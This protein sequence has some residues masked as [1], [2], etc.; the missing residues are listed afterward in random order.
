MVKNNK[1]KPTINI[2]HRSTMD[3]PRPSFSLTFIVRIRG[4]K[5]KAR[6]T[7]RIKGIT[8]FLLIWSDIAVTKRATIKKQKF[9][10]F[11]DIV[12]I[13]PF[14]SE[15][16]DIILPSKSNRVPWRDSPFLSQ[17]ARCH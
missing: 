15:V 9:L 4:C 2:P 8:I 1:V 12:F 16:N 10:S 6:K 7:E 5:I 3:V 11:S 17:T 13:A 14:N